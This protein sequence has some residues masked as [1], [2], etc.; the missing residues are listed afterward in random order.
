MCKKQQQTTKIKVQGQVYKSLRMFLRL[1]CQHFP[2]PRWSRGSTH[3]IWCNRRLFSLKQHI[4]SAN[5]LCLTQK[6]H[7]LP[8]GHCKSKHADCRFDPAQL[9]IARSHWRG[10]GGIVRL[11]TVSTKELCTRH[12]LFSCA[13]FLREVYYNT[14]HKFCQQKF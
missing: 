9:L 6:Y 2:L 13:S 1:S 5:G 10:L 3:H 12:P 4:P 11:L 7:Y 8:R 14:E